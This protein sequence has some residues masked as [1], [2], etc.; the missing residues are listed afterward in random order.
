M[1]SLNCQR[2][3]RQLELTFEAERPPPPRVVQQDL[4]M[5]TEES[6]EYFRGPSGVLFSDSNEEFN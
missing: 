3:T 4:Q 1:P 6:W 2:L 5:V